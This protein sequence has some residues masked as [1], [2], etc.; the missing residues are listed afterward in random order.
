MARVE[1]IL[2]SCPVIDLDN[3]INKVSQTT[4]HIISSGIDESGFSLKHHPKFLALL[5]E[6]KSGSKTHPKAAQLIPNVNKHLVFSFL[7]MSGGPFLLRLAE[8]GLDII[9]A[10]AK[11]GTLAIVTGTLK[12]WQD[13]M[14]AESLSQLTTQ[15]R[16]QFNKMGLTQSNLIS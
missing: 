13:V 1:A 4:G 7:I 16:P 14:A 15:I 8:F 5:G 6:L 3:F 10:K 12:Q 9:T 2:I 11:V